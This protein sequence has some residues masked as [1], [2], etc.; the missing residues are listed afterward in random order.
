MSN[1]DAWRIFLILIGILSTV[2]LFI[3]VL[4]MSDIATPDDPQNMTA[5]E[6]GEGVID[7]LKIGIVLIFGSIVTGAIIAFLKGLGG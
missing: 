7:I 6:A 5:T 4:D 1:S 2:G 3:S